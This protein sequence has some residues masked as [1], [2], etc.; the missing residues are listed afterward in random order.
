MLGMCKNMIAACQSC[1]RVRAGSKRPPWSL[2]LA[3]KG[4][5]GKAASPGARGHA[6]LCQAGCAEP[7]CAKTPCYHPTPLAPSDLVGTGLG[8]QILPLLVDVATGGFCS[9]PAFPTG[10]ILHVVQ[11]FFRST[12]IHSLCKGI[13]QLT[14]KMQHC[15]MQSSCSGRCT[16]TFHP[17]KWWFSPLKRCYSRDGSRRPHMCCQAG[18]TSPVCDGVLPVRGSCLQR[19]PACSQCH[20][21]SGGDI[22]PCSAHSRS[23][24]G[25]QAERCGR[26]A[27][28]ASHAPLRCD[29]AELWEARAS[30][31]EG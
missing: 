26:G 31:Q 4:R 29:V 13:T 21:G 2:L 15:M 24:T 19:G 18:E 16:R 12:G 25:A 20:R 14:K 17:W 22:P 11:G 5:A 6:C 30:E 8:S 9:A 23:S 27:Q 1:P 10:C 3:L 7:G 28:P